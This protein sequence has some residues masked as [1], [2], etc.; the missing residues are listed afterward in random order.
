MEI[1]VKPRT[2]VTV[3][4]VIAVLVAGYFYLIKTAEVRRYK[5]ETKQLRLIDEH[6]KLELSIIRQKAELDELQKN[7]P[8][9]SIPPPMPPKE[10]PREQELSRKALEAEKEGKPE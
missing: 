2:I 6:Q 3:G 10:S 4:L 9:M 1:K 7:P 8:Q 5:A